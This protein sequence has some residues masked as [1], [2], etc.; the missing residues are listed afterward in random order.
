MAKITVWQSKYVK[1][2]R[3]EDDLPADKIH[4]VVELGAAL[5]HE[6]D[7][8]AHFVPY[9][10]DKL[11]GC[12]RVNKA[13]L[14]KVREEGA[15]LVY[16][17]AVGDVDYRA[18]HEDGAAVPAEWHHAN[19]DAKE[20]IEKASDCIIGYYQTRGG[21]RF[22]WLTPEP[23]NPEA[24]LTYLARCRAA[25]AAEGVEL[26]PLTDWGRCYRLPFVEREGVPQRY[27]VWDLFSADGSSCVTSFTP[28]DPDADEQE[29]QAVFAGIEQA[30]GPFRLPAVIPPG[31]RHRLLVRYAG[32]LRHRGMGAEE[33]LACLLL[34]NE[35]RCPP[36]ARERRMAPEALAELGEIAR[37]VAEYEAGPQPEQADLDDVVFQRG[38][39]WE[40]ARHVLEQIEGEGPIGVYDQGQLWFYTPTT[41]RWATHPHNSMILAAG[42]LDGAMIVGGRQPLPLSMSSRK[43]RGCVDLMQAMRNHDGFFANAPAG[44]QFANGFAVVSRDGVEVH[45]NGPDWRS[46]IGKD[47]E[48]D[49]AA[50]CPRF[51]EFLDQVFAKNKDKEKTVR[52][53]QEFIGVSVLGLA[54][55][56]QTA[57]VLYGEG[58]NGKSTLQ[59]IVT[60]LL[61]ADYMTS[62]APQE[63]EN[64]YRRAMLAGAR[65]NVVNEMPEAAI[66]SGAAV[67]AIISGDQIVGRHIRQAPFAFKPTAGHLFSANELPR[68]DDLTPGQ[69]RRWIVICFDREFAKE[70]QVR[71]LDRSILAEEEA[72]IIVWA[73]QGAA[74]LMA[75]GNYDVP[76]QS[77]HAAKEWRHR[78]DQ[79]SQFVTERCE[80]DPEAAISAKELYMA[81]KLWANL[82]G[83]NAMSSTNFARRMTKLGIKS[84]LRKNKG[85]VSRVRH[86]RLVE[87]E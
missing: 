3:G 9:Y 79:V 82:S 20:A 15:D 10:I 23:L 58:A 83:H 78:S 66:M 53:L 12:P 77:L 6:Y 38:S 39:E 24:Y 60:G 61:P 51:V 63:F 26:D 87:N 33:I 19:R 22:I 75:R 74:A 28:R 48:F 52:L 50:K 37:G 16:E 1:G 45:P 70:E 86:L 27:P 40:L 18:A 68:L 2:W 84:Q 42:E 14:D 64:E 46:V 7:T 69:L 25:F 41:G 29:Q 73:L 32:V 35:Q 62:I 72:G 56:Y 57:C 49:A 85:K 55:R 36:E 17:V 8:D 47:Y 54:P 30:R 67:K 34:A 71:D 81:Y 21:G 59:S 80:R 5:R 13:A 43:A 11:D 44:L 4:P 65:L 31:Q 76:A